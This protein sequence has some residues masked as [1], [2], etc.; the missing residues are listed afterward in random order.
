MSVHSP[1]LYIEDEENDILLLRLAL[2]HAGV[3]NPL[4]TARDGEEGISYLAGSDQFADRN[5]Y[6]L[7]CAVLLDLNMP[8]KSGFEVLGWIRQ[9]PE[10]TTLPVVMYSSSPH[11]S[12]RAMALRLGADDYIPKKSKLAEIAEVA[13][14][15]NRRK[16][17]QGKRRT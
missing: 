5:R 2:K 1:I 7:P 4:V 11:E 17:I 8:R 16:S 3:P 12:D 6:P 9:R 14:L 13:K 15:L 10:F